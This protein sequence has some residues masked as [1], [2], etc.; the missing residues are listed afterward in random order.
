MK[1]YNVKTTVKKYGNTNE[2][3]FEKVMII[4]D[5]DE[6]DEFIQMTYGCWYEIISFDSE[7]VQVG[8]SKTF[9]K[10]EAMKLIKENM[11]L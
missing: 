9:I 7:E 4:G 5:S 1:S 3:V 10:E 6:L 11:L 2:E 8:I